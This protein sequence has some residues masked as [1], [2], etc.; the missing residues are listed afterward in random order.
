MAKI[1]PGSPTALEGMPAD[2]LL[3]GIVCLSP[4]LVGSLR[5]AVLAHVAGS[6]EDEGL[7]ME[8]DWVLY[9]ISLQ[10]PS[11]FLV[12]PPEDCRGNIVGPDRAQ[13]KSTKLEGRGQGLKE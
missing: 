7:N 5:D 11:C 6:M 8:R 12:V 1:I 4:A 3:A 13:E 2:G 9:S 10:R